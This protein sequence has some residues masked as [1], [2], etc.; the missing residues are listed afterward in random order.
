MSKCK[1]RQ[2]RGVDP[3]AGVEVLAAGE[4]NPKLPKFVVAAHTFLAANLQVAEKEKFRDEKYNSL[5]PCRVTVNLKWPL[6]AVGGRY[7]ERQFDIIKMK[8]R[9]E[10]A[11]SVIV[12]GVKGL[13]AHGDGLIILEPQNIIAVNIMQQG[14]DYVHG[15]V[16]ATLARSC[17]YAWIVSGRKLAEKVV[18]ECALCSKEKARLCSP[19]IADV[20]EDR[21]APTKPF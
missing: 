19:I 15:G 21:L 11:V 12:N 2:R 16:Q 20:T 6:P 13:S 14:H 9:G 3:A 18:K 8:G 10:T 5:I 1:S 4:D 17:A 7:E